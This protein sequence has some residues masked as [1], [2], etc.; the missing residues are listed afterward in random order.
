MLV[1]PIVAVGATATARAA[2]AAHGND[3]DVVALADAFLERISADRK[4]SFV[5]A[6]E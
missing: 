4:T 5:T 6:D 2:L 1:A 3:N